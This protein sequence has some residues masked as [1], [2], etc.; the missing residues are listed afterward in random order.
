MERAL[1]FFDASYPDY[2]YI[3]GIKLY[4]LTLGQIMRL[5]KMHNPW[6]DNNATTPS[7]EGLI[8]GLFI[9]SQREAECEEWFAEKNNWDGKWYSKFILR[10]PYWFTTFRCFDKYQYKKWENDVRDFVLD[11][12][13]KVKKM[14]D[15]N[16]ME[17]I[18]AFTNYVK[19]SE[20]NPL[21]DIKPTKGKPNEFRKDAYLENILVTLCSEMK[22]TEEEVKDM[23]MVKAIYL[24]LKIAEKNGAVEFVGDSAYIGMERNA[25]L[26]KT[27]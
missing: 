15:F 12:E 26:I 7:V 23:P 13:K 27:V 6:V 9:C 25:H 17:A 2:T 16:L 1:D 10:N 20:K 11:L 14:N 4:P 5:K 18:N 21:I 24:F 22:K 19:E 3:W 8:M